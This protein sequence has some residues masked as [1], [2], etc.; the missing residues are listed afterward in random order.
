MGKRL[1]SPVTSYQS[2]VI[3][4]NVH[5]VIVLAIFFMS[6]WITGCYSQNVTAIRQEVKEPASLEQENKDSYLWDFGKVKEGTILEHEFFV[7]NESKVVLNIKDINTSCGCTVS[8]VRKKKLLPGES[9][10]IGV[11]FNSKGY[12]GQVTQYIYMNTDAIDTSTALSINGERSRTLDNS[13]VRYII[14]AEVVK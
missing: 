4:D 3:T 8:E 6:F 1:L 7:K 14:K 10:L 13:I 11:K 2:P 5:R 12:S 9:T